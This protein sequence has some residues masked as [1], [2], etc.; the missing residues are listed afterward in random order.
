LVGGTAS[1]KRA[2]Q[3]A[4]VSLHAAAFRIE[5]RRPQFKARRHGQ[6]G[7]TEPG[8]L[9]ETAEAPH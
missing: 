9:A 1:L 6:I 8:R 4:G 7:A 5:V 3:E 2:P